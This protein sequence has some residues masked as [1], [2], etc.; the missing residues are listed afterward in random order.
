[1][2]IIAISRQVA[3]L[4]DEIA[5]EVA[6]RLG[7]SF[8]G[9]QAIE[10]KIVELGFPAEK[11]SK[12]DERKPGFFA[13]L[14]KDRDEYLN[15]LQ[16]AVLEAAS[17]QNCILIGRGSFVIL[18]DIPNLISLRFVA[19]ESIRLKRLMNE[20]SWDEKQA[21]QRIDE[22]DL[23]R[24]GFHKSFFNLSNDD[25][26]QFHL[27]MNTGILDI[28][29]GSDVIVNLVNTLIT[30]EL[31]ATGKKKLDE[32][33]VAQHLVNTLIFK[34]KINISFLKAVVTDAQIVLQGVADSSALVEKAISISKELMP[35]YTV[36]SAISIVQ[37]FKSYP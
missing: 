26:D 3:A 13:S 18:E 16:T 19:A 23:N 14:A 28:N 33:L 31:E 22:S 5:G 12:Y 10:K 17:Q 36:E 35:N 24:T 6:K 34:H 4:G 20:F 25:S 1:M 37:D 21:Q 9:R 7:Y 15:Y 29:S 32:L 2:A 30:P 27:V 8:V 11:L